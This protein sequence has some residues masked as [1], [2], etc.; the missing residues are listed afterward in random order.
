MLAFRNAPPDQLRL[1]ACW[2]NYPAAHHY[3]GPLVDILSLVYE[4]KDW[5]A[6]VGDGQSSS[7]SGPKN[8]KRLKNAEVD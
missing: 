6:G 3:D 1:H 4:S 8:D 7:N 5:G 2:G